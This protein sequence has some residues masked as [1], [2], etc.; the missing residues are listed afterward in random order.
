[1]ALCLLVNKRMIDHA[2]IRMID[3]QKPTTV[4]LASVMRKGENEVGLLRFREKLD[5]AF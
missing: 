5:S 4:Y 1:M 2:E 3:P